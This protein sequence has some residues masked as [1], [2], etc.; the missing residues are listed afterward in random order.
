MLDGEIFIWYLNVV[1]REAGFVPCFACSF[2]LTSCSFCV[3]VIS[4]ERSL[5]NSL[6]HQTLWL[7][8]QSHASRAFGTA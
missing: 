8:S 7:E 6:C 5:P 2:L 1:V 4:I 3:A